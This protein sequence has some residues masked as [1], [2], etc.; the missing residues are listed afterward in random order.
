MVT[1]GGVAVGEGREG[2]RE[3]NHKMA[4]GLYLKHETAGK[5]ERKTALLTITIM[6]AYWLISAMLVPEK[7]VYRFRFL[8]LCCLAFSN[9][10]FTL[11]FDLWVASETIL[12]TDHLNFIVY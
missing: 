9:T 5:A 8:V 1:L 7:L 10:R 3:C 11:L 4:D 2:R 6:A 12:T